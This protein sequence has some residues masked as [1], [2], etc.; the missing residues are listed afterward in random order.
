MSFTQ[1]NAVAV[2]W[3]NRSRCWRTRVRCPRGHTH[4][5]YPRMGSERSAPIVTMGKYV[6]FVSSL[7]KSGE[8]AASIPI[9]CQPEEN[10][11]DGPVRLTVNGRQLVW[12][13]RYLNT[14]GAEKTLLKTRPS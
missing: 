14:L 13:M 8:E 12:R 2:S 5:R 9:P 6:N 1:D 4:L 3:Q 7:P 10:R 11:G